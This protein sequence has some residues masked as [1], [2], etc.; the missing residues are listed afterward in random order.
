MPLINLDRLKIPSALMF[1]M[2]TS[3]HSLASMFWIHLWRGMQ[4]RISAKVL[5][6]PFIYPIVTSFAI[7]SWTYL[8]I[9]EL[10]SLQQLMNGNDV[11]SDRTMTFLLKT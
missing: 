3:L 8:D 4:L 2:V 6:V 10:L 1:M 7:I 11:L 9:L 5:V